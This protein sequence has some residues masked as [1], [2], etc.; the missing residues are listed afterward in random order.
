MSYKQEEFSYSV[1]YISIFWQTLLS[2][3]KPHIGLKNSILSLLVCNA[4]KRNLS[5]FT[6]L[7]EWS[8]SKNTVFQNCIFAGKYL[9]LK[10]NGFGYLHKQYLNSVAITFRALFRDVT[11]QL[12]TL[13]QYKWFMWQKNDHYRLL[14][15]RKQNLSS[16]KL[17]K[18]YTLA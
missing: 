10:T 14:V 1:E 13:R 6:A 2:I 7:K 18:K 3:N 12:K 16:L 9:F 17:I 4:L 11:K 8:Q 5:S 15:A